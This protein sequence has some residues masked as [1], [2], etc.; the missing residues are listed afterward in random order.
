MEDDK[1]YKIPVEGLEQYRITKS[2]K[3]WS[4]N[5]KCYIS[6]NIVNGYEI[7]PL[8]E[9]PHAVHR[10]VAITFIPNPDNK[11]QVRH[12]DNNKLNNHLDNLCWATQKEVV[13]SHGK[14][15]SHARKVLQYDLEDNLVNTFN[16]SIEAGKSI[17][18]TPSA[19]SKVLIGKNPTA[20][21]FKW[22]YSEVDKPN[23]IEL[24]L[25]QAKQID[26]HEK[27]NIFPDGRVYNNVRKT[28]LKPVVNSSG[29]S[30]VTLSNNDTKGNHYVHRLVAEHFLMATKKEGHTQVNHKNKIRSDNNI[31]NLE[32]CSASENLKHAFNN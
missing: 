22:K 1:K 26:E 20:G 28:F 6:L 11:P 15:T 13:N 7:V 9:H 5:T 32:W 18:C 25:S 10:L 31:D 29:Y 3:V 17:N 16:S 30:Y 8:R 23:V 14:K 19:I 21:G 4:K 24:D 2:G 12:I 27:Y